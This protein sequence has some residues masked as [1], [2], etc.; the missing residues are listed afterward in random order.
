MS[1]LRKLDWAGGRKIPIFIREILQGATAL[2]AGMA[3]GANAAT[4]Y[5]AA[6]GLWPDGH[7]DERVALCANRLFFHPHLAY[8]AGKGSFP[9]LIALCSG[10]DDPSHGVQCSF[11]DEAAPALAPV[12]APKLYFGAYDHMLL[13]LT[14]GA[15]GRPLRAR[16]GG[17]GLPESVAL[18][19]S[20]ETGLFVALRNPDVRVFV[21]PTKACVLSFPV[22]WPEV[23]SVEVISHARF[24]GAG[25]PDFKD[26]QPRLG[27]KLSCVSM[28]RPCDSLDAIVH[29]SYS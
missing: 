10:V 23:A 20:V 22:E 7:E 15:S 11:L 12:R 3:P 24:D 18:T 14:F 9:A 16:D 28:F 13:P 25:G 5:L 21:A 27:A 4:R 29:G 6:L 2:H 17:S 1:A 19:R 8:W 26:L